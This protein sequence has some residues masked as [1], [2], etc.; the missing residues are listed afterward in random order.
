[1]FVP[2]EVST[3]LTT[4]MTIERYIAILHP[5]AYKVQVTKRKILLSVGFCSVL[6]IFL[7]NFLVTF[8]NLVRIYAIAK[9]AFVLFLTVYTYTRIYTGTVV[10]KLVRCSQMKP[11]DVVENINLTKMKLFLR[12]IKQTK[13]CFVVVVCFFV[14]GFLPPANDVPFAA[15]A[16]EF[17]QFGIF[18]WTFSINV[19]NSTANSV[20]FFWTKTMLRKEAFK[21]LNFR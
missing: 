18:F 2:I 12:E 4:A 20:I 19:L 6:S 15:R 3:V 11:H 5:Y 7:A 9:V 8:Q 16:N 1:M 17:E 10:R 14:L 21:L 13:S